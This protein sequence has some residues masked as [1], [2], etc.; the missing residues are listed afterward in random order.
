MSLGQVPASHRG[1]IVAYLLFRGFRRDASIQDPA[2]RP[3]RDQPVP[4]T[5]SAAPYAGYTCRAAKA[6]PRGAS[7]S[8]PTSTAA[9]GYQGARKH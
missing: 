6:L 4:R 9:W 8:A 2:R 1:G 5:W 3:A 7:S